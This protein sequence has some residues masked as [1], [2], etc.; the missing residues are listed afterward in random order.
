MLDDLISRGSFQLPIF[1]LPLVLFP[2]EILPLHI[3]EDKY[4][5]MLADTLAGDN[6]FGI[7][8]FE[9]VDAQELR[10]DIG[11]I[12]CIAEVQEST[13]LADGRSNIVTFGRVRIRI[14]DFV[15]TAEPYFVAEVE[16]LEDIDDDPEASS[17]LAETVFDLFTRVAKAAFEIGGSRGQFPKLE[18][19]D[20]EALSFLVAAGFNFENEVK[21]KMLE[22]T[23]TFDRLSRLRE[24]LST[25]VVRIEE[26]AEIHS[27]AKTN[28]HS[29]KSVD[30]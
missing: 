9:P 4:R 29:K 6:G 11:S 3:F 17:E 28:G 7:V 24:I 25:T 12:G 23:S 2:G 30:L 18:W 16:T 8:L 19:S 21:Q 15:V 1:P 27:V 14:R 22:I 10:P 13:L 5:K 26:S 20:P